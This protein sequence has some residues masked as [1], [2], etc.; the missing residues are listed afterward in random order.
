MTKNLRIFCVAFTL[1]VTIAYCDDRM[2]DS[3]DIWF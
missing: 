2:R 1:G 3:K